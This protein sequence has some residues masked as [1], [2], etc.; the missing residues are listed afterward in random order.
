MSFEIAVGIGE[1]ARNELPVFSPFPTMFSKALSFRIY[2]SR[3]CVLKSKQDKGL[4][5]ID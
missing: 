2:K 1:I 4:Q 5:L 3:D